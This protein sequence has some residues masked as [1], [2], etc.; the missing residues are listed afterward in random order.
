MC[1]FVKVVVLQ[2]TPRDPSSRPGASW[3]QLA[4]VNREVKAASITQPQGTKDP[5]LTGST[6]PFYRQLQNKGLKGQDTQ[7]PGF[8][9]MNKL[10]Q[11]SPFHK[12]ACFTRGYQIDAIKHTDTHTVLQL[13]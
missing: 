13:G 11:R 5:G 3:S 6:P 9:T 8:K 2:L 10:C 1:V 4:L 12:C 7:E